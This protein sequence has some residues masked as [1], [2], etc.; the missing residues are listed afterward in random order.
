MTFYC[1]A[2][3]CCTSDIRKIAQ[4]ENLVILQFL[5]FTARCGALECIKNSKG[6]KQQTQLRNM[7][8]YIS[9]VID[10]VN[11]GQGKGGKNSFQAELGF[12]RVD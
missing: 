12:V 2:F 5:P 11:L 1:L 10:L 4:S 3:Y 9:Y 7:R 6:K 8:M